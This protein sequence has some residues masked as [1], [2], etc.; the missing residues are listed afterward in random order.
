M[1][2]HRSAASPCQRTSSLPPP[3]PRKNRF[4]PAGS[5]T[6]SEDVEN[7]IFSIM[8]QG[9]MFL[10]HLSFYTEN[11]QW[12]LSFSPEAAQ[13]CVPCP[14]CTL[15]WQSRES[16]GWAVEPQPW[17][18]SELRPLWPLV[19]GGLIS[20]AAITAQRDWSS[21]WQTLRHTNLSDSSSVTQTKCQWPTGKGALTQ[22]INSL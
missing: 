8:L 3:V 17:D 13:S 21:P 12:S 11:Q 7:E 18:P 16:L 10:H 15:S 19:K 5:C 22:Q 9:V 6:G 1:R 4:L 20:K 14:S 2:K